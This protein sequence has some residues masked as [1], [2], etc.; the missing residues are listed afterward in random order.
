MIKMTGRILFKTTH[1]TIIRSKHNIM[2]TET[3]S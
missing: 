3:L 2:D 1:D